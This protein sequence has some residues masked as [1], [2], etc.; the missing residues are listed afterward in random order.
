PNFETICASSAC[1]GK[2]DCILARPPADCMLDRCLFPFRINSRTDCRVSSPFESDFPQGCP[3]TLTAR[4]VLGEDGRIAARLERYECRPEQ[5]EMAEA[6]ERAIANRE[7]LIV[8]AGTGVGKSFAY[9]VP[10]ILA[11][12]TKKNPN[13]KRIRIVV[14]AHT[15]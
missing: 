13:G 8:E 9:L 1:I 12:S 2:H 11:A 10:A 5:P 6:V 15:I 4:S 14:S 7:H 3:V